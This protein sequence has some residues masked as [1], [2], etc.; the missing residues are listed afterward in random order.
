MKKKINPKILIIEDVTV[1]RESLV[2]F[3]REEGFRTLEAANGK[4]GLEVANLENPDLIVTNIEM[5]FM[6][7][8][9]LFKELDKE[10]NKI[11]FIFITG[12]PLPE[13]KAKGKQ[14]G[15]YFEKPVDIEELVKEIKKI[16]GF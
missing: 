3:L 15:A 11:P 2:F 4:E 9:A 16:T 6:D 7:G 12:K 5:P 10:N 14:Y 8:F 1:L 13:F